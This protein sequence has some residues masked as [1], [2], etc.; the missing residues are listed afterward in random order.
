[1][2]TH[3][4]TIIG[5][6][7]NSG[8]PRRLFLPIGT[9]T[10]IRIE[11]FMKQ[12]V[13]GLPDNKSGVKKCRQYEEPKLLVF[14]IGLSRRW[15]FP[16]QHNSHKR[17]PKIRLVFFLYHCHKQISRDNSNLNCTQTIHH[18]FPNPELVRKWNSHWTGYVLNSS[19]QRMNWLET[20]LWTLF[21]SLPISSVEIYIQILMF[22]R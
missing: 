13:S 5:R 8:N 12:T 6:S 21:T 11:R 22:H 7:N 3:Y 10:G 9:Q 15:R 1:M 2:Y 18:R 20:N 14:V 4:L 16:H 19:L 17:S